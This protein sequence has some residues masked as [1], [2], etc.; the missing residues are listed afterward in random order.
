MLTYDD[1]YHIM[2]YV[3]YWHNAINK[4]NEIEQVMLRLDQAR[5]VEEARLI[6]SKIGEDEEGQ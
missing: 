3:L 4:H 6:L 5:N 2:F 1:K